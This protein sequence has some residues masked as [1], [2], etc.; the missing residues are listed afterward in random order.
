[1]Y[2]V[3]WGIHVL[4]SLPGIYKKFKNQIFAD[5]KIPRV[6]MPVKIKNQGKNKLWKAVF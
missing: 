3:N 6:Y 5:L 2:F 4:L 1:M